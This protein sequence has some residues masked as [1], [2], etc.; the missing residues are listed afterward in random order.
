MASLL[1]RTAHDV[2]RRNQ[3]SILMY[4]ALIGFST[5]AIFGNQYL[6]NSSSLLVFSVG[7]VGIFG[8]QVLNVL[9]IQSQRPVPLLRIPLTRHAWV[10]NSLAFA[11]LLLL[12]ICVWRLVFIDYIF[13]NDPDK[14]DFSIILSLFFLLSIAA[15]FQIFIPTEFNEQGI[16]HQ[17]LVWQWN[18]F[19]SYYWD[20]QYAVNQHRDLILSLNEMRGMK[21]LRIAVG[22]SQV[23]QVQEFLASRLPS[24][25]EF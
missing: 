24:P 17:G 22:A 4:I 6:E 20:P 5:L 25:T 23:T 2:R 15:T 7:I 18:C 8:P 9:I 16:I 11:L 14:L 12:I 1:Y 10:I 3:F 13:G 21:Q 19:A